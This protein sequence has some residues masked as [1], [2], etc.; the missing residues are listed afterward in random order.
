MKIFTSKKLALLTVATGTFM[1]A[2]DSSVVNLT[3]PRIGLY[4]K[5]SLSTIEWTVMAYLLVIS[6]LLLVYGKLGDMYGHK[7]ICSLG[8]LIFTVGSLFCGLSF[9][10]GLLIVSRVIQAVG[11]GMLMAIGP[12]IVTV[13]AAPTERGRALSVVAVAVAIALT[14]GPVVG[15]FLAARL[16]WQ[17]IFYINLPI[18]LAGRLLAQKTIPERRGRTVPTFDFPGAALIFSALSCLLLPLSLVERYGWNNSYI[19]TAIAA[20]LA[21]VICFVF[22]EKHTVTPMFDIDLFKKPLFAMSNFASLL[23]FMAQYTVILLIPFYL[24]ELRGMTPDKAGLLYLPMPLATMIVAPISGALSD[25]LDSRFLS[26][27]GMAFMAL[28][29]W[30]LSGLGMDTSIPAILVRMFLIGVGI[31]LLQ[32]PNNSA[33]MGCAPRS[34]SGIASGMLAMMRNI[35]MVTGV[36]ISGAIF[37]SSR[38]RLTETLKISGLTGPALKEAA[39]TGALHL[40]YLIAAG[41]AVVA[42]IASLVKGSTRTENPL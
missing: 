4:F 11:A 36:A 12:A 20:G 9:T 5:A 39:F 22:W 7:R 34:K 25:R 38:R 24:Q 18:G 6:S 29:M 33:V 31:G 2:L 1:S 40:T 15:G 14:L 42:V 35:G 28:G 17:S 19:R 23:N 32:T 26:A 10:V 37:S 3:L 8:F 41:F 16:G 27:A 30:L 21:L 13:T